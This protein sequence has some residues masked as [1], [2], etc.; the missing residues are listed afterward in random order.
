MIDGAERI[1]IEQA[2]STVCHL[3]DI[4]GKGIRRGARY[5]ASLHPSISEEF[6]VAVMIGEDVEAIK[7]AI[8]QMEALEK[9]FPK[10]FRLEW[11]G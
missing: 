8:S 3:S 11:H 2:L 10:L 7:K 4:Y 5:F 1:A 9:M 6:A